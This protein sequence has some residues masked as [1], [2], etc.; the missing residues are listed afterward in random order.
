[1]KQRASSLKKNKHNKPL[2]RFNKNEKTQINKVRSERTYNKYQ[3]NTKI[4][5]EYNEDYMIPI[6]CLEEKIFRNI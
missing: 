2:A 3:R 4:I 5:Q 1:M 6:Q